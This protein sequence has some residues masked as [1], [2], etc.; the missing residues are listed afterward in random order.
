MHRSVRLLSLGSAIAASLGL[1]I[2]CGGSAV[3]PVSDGGNDFDAT[4]TLDSGSNTDAG[5]GGGNDSANDASTID[6]Y[7]GP[8]VAVR[9]TNCGNFAACGGD[10]TG[11]FKVSD[12]CVDTDAVL[13]VA[14]K[15]CPNIS[16]SNW[17]GQGAGGLTVAGNNWASMTQTKM[18]VDIVVPSE[19][20]AQFFSCG[21]L[22]AGLKQR[23]FDT[24]TCKDNAGGGCDCSVSTSFDETSNGAFT[25]N[26][27]RI[28]ASNNVAYDYCRTDKI[29]TLNPQNDGAPAPIYYTYSE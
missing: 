14:K 3:T 25:Q 24:A 29:V 19:C 11:V 4:Q 13:A 27:S 16:A 2:A 17:A 15:E 5:D 23:G 26:G 8:P 21:F 6:V 28:V 9:F 1:A 10:P 7:L 12:I 22:A 20:K 18:S